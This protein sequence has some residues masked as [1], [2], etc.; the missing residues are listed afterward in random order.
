MTYQVGPA[1]PADD[2]V[3]GYGGAEP[4]R[5]GRRIVR[6]VLVALVMAVFAG[7]L[8]VAYSAMRGHG[9][10]E[11]PLIRADGRPTKTRPEQPGGMAIRALDKGVFDMGRNQTGVEKLLPPP[12]APLPRPTPP[13]T[14][15]AEPSAVVAIPPVAGQL[16]VI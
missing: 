7:G 3:A 1:G 13:S 5:G 8:W 9:G 15:P 14:Q 10:G 16:P 12:D 6:L 11:V 2:D 4:V